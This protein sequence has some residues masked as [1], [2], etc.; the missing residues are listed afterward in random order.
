MAATPFSTFFRTATGGREPYPY[1]ER[2]AEATPLPHLLRAPTGAG[3]TATAV[4]G[5]L[6]R[7]VS[8][9]A[10]T[11]RRLVY[12]L[13]MRVLVE[14]SFR[15]VAKWIDNTDIDISLRLLM[16]GVEDE[17]WYLEPEKPAVLIGTQDMLL[18]RALNRGYAASRFHWPIDCGLL[19]ND[20]LWVF[21]EPQ[22]MANGVSTSAQLAGLRKALGTFGPCPSV[23]M[24]ATLEPG[25]LE[26]IDFRGQFPG[27]PLELNEEDYDPIFSLKQR[28]TAEKTLHPLGVPSSKD[29]KEVAKRVLEEHAVGTRTLVILNTVDRAKAVYEAIKKDRKAPTKLLLV[30][31]R[32]RPQERVQ[33]NDD[34]QQQGGAATNRI[35]VATQVVEAGVDISARTLVTEVAPWASVVQRIGRCN[36]TGGDGPGRVFWID[37]EEKSSLPYQAADLDF[38]RQQLKKLEGAG[39]SPKDFDEFKTKQEITLPF[40]H[41]HVL[42]RRDLLDLFDT[43]PDLSGNDIDVQRFVRSDDPDTDV[44]VFWRA[45][46]AEGPPADEPSP[47]RR[48]LCSV[49]VGQARD[50]LKLLGEKKRGAGY[51]WDHLDERW[52]KL[53]PKM[54]RPGLVI[55]LPDWAGGYDW[56]DA[57]QSGKGWDPGNP[58]HVTPLPADF[59]PEEAAGGDPNS[60]RGGPPLTIRQHTAN[61]CRELDGLLRSLGQLIPGWHEHL[62][63]AARWHDVGKAHEAFQQG[64]RTANPQ[65]AAD[66]LWAKSG[67]RGS[68]RH[69]RKHFRHELASA[70]VAL[71]QRLPFE[72]AYLIAAHHGRVRL[73]IRPLPGEDPPPDPK[74]LFA[75]G[76]HHG[77]KLTAVELGDGQTCP[78]DQL[79]LSP[80][81]LGG[82][83]SWTANAL[84]LLADLGP[85]K[86][87]YLEALL[88]A[89][90]VRASKK[91]AGDA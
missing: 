45:I 53:D 90:D 61:V 10:D 6:W 16:G 57:T 48:E 34:L 8:K 41:K 32:F 25:W 1:Q 55:L 23:W 88:R 47:Q 14:Q 35:I 68:L 70:L 64:I 7:W 91:E 18:S 51:S 49:P 31:S 66:Q 33:L 77:D 2:F 65:L 72:A 22:L 17:E 44:Q 60:A 38:A 81:R 78:E 19:N 27:D 85:F 28:M 39:V 3:K 42:R 50:F 26:T 59:G 40:E 71:Q 87:A 83:R 12:C 46:P 37:L 76:V 62:T 11:P 56:D 82:E 36:R 86:L 84:R 4:L 58:K 9:Q 73:A 5:W 74:V 67:T 43:A 13:P 79:D 80:M 21:D 24:S 20:C 54:V 75:L 15:E 89:A 69:G 30:H 29:M 52:M 63:K